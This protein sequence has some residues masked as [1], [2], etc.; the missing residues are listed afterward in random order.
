MSPSGHASADEY[1]FLRDLD[2]TPATRRGGA[3]DKL[4]NHL[5]PQAMAQKNH[6]VF[7]LTGAKSV[8]G[9]TKRF[10]SGARRISG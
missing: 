7:G 5:A 2:T 4:R 6:A 3:A 1:Q 8:S 10:V 9:P